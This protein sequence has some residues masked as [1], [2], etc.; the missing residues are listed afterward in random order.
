MLIYLLIF[1][2][3][4]NKVINKVTGALVTISVGRTVIVIWNYL[5]KI[6]HRDLQPLYTEEHHPAWVLVVLYWIDQS[7]AT[8]M[9][10]H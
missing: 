9:N 7:E 1:I 3:L 2:A 4:T 5:S 8:L 10:V 6:H